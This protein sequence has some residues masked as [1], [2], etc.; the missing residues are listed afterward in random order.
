MNEKLK[1][2]LNKIV[3]K[4]GF[5]LQIKLEN[6]NE[7]SP[8]WH[9]VGRELFW[10]MDNHS[11]FID[12]VYS[13]NRYTRKVVSE[14]KKT[15]G[16]EWI[17]ISDIGSKIP[18]RRMMTL[19]KQLD[20]QSRGNPIWEELEMN[21]VKHS[22]AFCLV[23]GQDECNP[24]LE[25]LATNLLIGTEDFAKKDLIEQIDGALYCQY[26]PVIITNTPLYLCRMNPTTVN[27]NTGIIES[28]KEFE[29]IDSIVFQ[30][31]FW[32]K[33]ETGKEPNYSSK[34]PLNVAQDRSVIIVKS[35]H[36]YEFLN[37]IA[38]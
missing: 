33:V 38:K 14:V 2:R 19:R 25:R 3:D 35:S 9:V 17:F 28:E 16:G 26:Y 23:S 10:E 15:S 5:P 4:S 11:G 13:H 34:Y 36:F 18:L 7:L 1:G 21:H 24:M 12:T 27:L 32:T 6:E 31:P 29:E 22:S 37:D 30:K 20:R 8:N